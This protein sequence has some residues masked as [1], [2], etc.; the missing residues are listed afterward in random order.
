MEEDEWYH[1][2]SQRMLR[3]IEIMLQENF[4]PQPVPYTS[5]SFMPMPEPVQPQEA[6]QPIPSEPNDNT[7]QYAP[8][9]ETKTSRRQY[10]AQEDTEAEYKAQFMRPTVQ[11]RKTFS[12][13]KEG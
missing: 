3:N 13:K 11:T 5:G 12:P 7:Q 1:T 4:Y 2:N 6:P 8:Y 10:E 9:P